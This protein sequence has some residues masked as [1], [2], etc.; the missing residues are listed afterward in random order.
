LF[1]YAELIFPVL[2]L[3]QLTYAGLPRIQQWRAALWQDSSVAA[4]LQEL[5]PAAQEWVESKL[6]QQQQQQQQQR[7][8]S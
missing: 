6:L 7:A 2:G 8:S 4:V 5:K 3:G 1:L